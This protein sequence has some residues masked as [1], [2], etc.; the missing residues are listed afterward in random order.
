LLETG[1][2]CIT[3]LR[4]IFDENS[5]SEAQILAPRAP[6]SSSNPAGSQKAE[7]KKGD[8]TSVKVKRLLRGR[9]EEADK[10]LDFLVSSLFTRPST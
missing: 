6:V 10:L 7:Q 8:T 3:Y 5:F 4:G 1:V 9:S 2:A